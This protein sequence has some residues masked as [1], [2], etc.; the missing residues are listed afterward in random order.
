[1]GYGMQR[2][3]GEYDDEDP[4]I[5]RSSLPWRMP[6]LV[7]I[8]LLLHAVL[9][10]VVFM[11]SAWPWA[12]AIMAVNHLVIT[13]VGLWPRSHWLGPNW[14]HL[15]AAAIARREIALTI[16]DGPHPDIT[17][18]VLDLLDRY[19]VKATFFCIGDRAAQ[20]PALCQQI[21]ARGHAIGNHSQSHRHY[22]SLLGMA[23]LT[24]EI[25]AGQ[26]TIMRI[27]GQRPLFFRAP[28]GLRNIFL[29]PVL[30][31]LGLRLAAWSRRGYDTRSGDAALVCRRLSRGLSA[32]AILLVHDGHCA[33]TPAGVPV[34]LDV[35]P[36][37]IGTARD[38]GLRFVTLPCALR[39]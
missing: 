24:R 19:D 3:T 12:L 36:M 22:F 37:L 29:D 28:A 16:D 5:A 6:L 34:V 32:G 35:L 4:V 1:M 9:L 7:R 23:A 26:D 33:L 13:A 31:R 14:T 15:P 2:S 21:V 30:A 38:A 11:P 17:P 18:H 20:Y 27:T 10:L 39:A 8:T 25:Q